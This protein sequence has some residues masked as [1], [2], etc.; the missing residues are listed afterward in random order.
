MFPPLFPSFPA[1]GTGC[2]FSRAWHQLHFFPRFAPVG[3]FP[4]LGT[5]CIFS[6]AWYR[7]H[8][9]PRFAPVAI[10]SAL[11][12]GCIF[13]RAC[14]RLVFLFPLAHPN[15]SVWTSKWHSFGFKFLAIIKKNNHNPLAFSNRY[16]KSVGMTKK[17]MT[18]RFLHSHNASFVF[19]FT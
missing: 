19:A 14:H 17:E 15:V 10:F 18:T 7:L 1:L 5:G 11:G 4:A 8:L 13:S 12:T 3:S 2:I 6:R 9:F 16:R